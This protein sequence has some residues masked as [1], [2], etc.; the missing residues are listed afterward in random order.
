MYE[1]ISNKKV[2]YNN[3]GEIVNEDLNSKSNVNGPLPCRFPTKCIRN[4]L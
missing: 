2:R 4:K 3:L 1:N